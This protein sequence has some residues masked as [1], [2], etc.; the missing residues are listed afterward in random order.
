MFAYGP[1]LSG[2][3]NRLDLLEPPSTWISIALRR[4]SRVFNLQLSEGF[5]ILAKLEYFLVD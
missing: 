4:S 5:T 2:I 1:W 3:F